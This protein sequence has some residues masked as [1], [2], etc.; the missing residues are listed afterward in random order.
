LA[1]TLNLWSAG[2][3][4]EKLNYMHANPV[5]RG[6]VHLA[7]EW[8]WSSYRYYHSEHPA[9]LAMDHLP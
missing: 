2:K 1:E 8:P 7:Q 4:L 3:I 5:K 6:L 9:A